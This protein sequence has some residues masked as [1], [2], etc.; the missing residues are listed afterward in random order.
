MNIHAEKI[1][2]IIAE[3]RALVGGQTNATAATG[4]SS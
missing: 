1:K 3:L 2:G 4:L